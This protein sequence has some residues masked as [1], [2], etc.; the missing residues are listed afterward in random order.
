MS[1]TRNERQR[2]D[3]IKAVAATL[4]NKPM[5]DNL[6]ADAQKNQRVVWQKQLQLRTGCTAVTAR[7]YI[8]K[9]LKDELPNTKV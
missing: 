3:H 9:A 6:P 8:R 7:A 1:R 2:S 5:Y 4:V